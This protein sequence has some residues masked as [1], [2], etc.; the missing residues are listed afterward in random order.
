MHLIH[1]NI[2]GKLRNEPLLYKLQGSPGHSS[3]SYQS[4]L[5]QDHSCEK[6]SQNKI[7]IV[8]SCFLDKV[9]H[10]DLFSCHLV[11]KF[12]HFISHLLGVFSCFPQTPTHLNCTIYAYAYACEAYTLYIYIYIQLRHLKK[13]CE[14]SKWRFD[15]K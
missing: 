2:L 15:T 14:E 5:D 12:Q 8:T 11:S 4:L 13:T 7:H 9:S 1:K 3:S 10:F 6:L